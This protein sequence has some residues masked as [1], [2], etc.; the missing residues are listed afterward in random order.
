MHAPRTALVTGAADWAQWVRK[1]VSE[2]YHV[3]LTA[4]NI[5]K[6]EEA[7]INAGFATT[8]VRLLDWM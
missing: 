6:A 4:R 7:A 8:Q 2:D 3:Y 1:L 5:V